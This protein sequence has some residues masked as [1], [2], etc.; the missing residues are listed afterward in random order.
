MIAQSVPCQDCGLDAGFDSWQEQE[1]FVSLRMSRPALEPTQPPCPG[2]IRGS[3]LGTWSWPLTLLLVHRFRMNE[4]IPLPFI[5]LHGVQ[6]DNF[7]FMFYANH[8]R[9]ALVTF[10]DD[11]LA[12]GHSSHCRTKHECSSNTK[13]APSIINWAVYT[14]KVNP[15]AQKWR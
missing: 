11:L 3:F 14:W 1:I 10:S 2:G 8:R 6:R 12:H 5:C 13:A 7:T 15:F 9:S 4:A